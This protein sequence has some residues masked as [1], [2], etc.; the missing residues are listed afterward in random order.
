LS[1]T[2]SIAPSS[3]FGV[4]GKLR[5]PITDLLAFADVPFV[6]LTTGVFE[7]LPWEHRHSSV[8]EKPFSPDVLIA[9]VEKG[10]DPIPRPSQRQSLPNGPVP[11]PQVVRRF[12]TAPSSMSGS[13]ERVFCR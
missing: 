8:V 2:A 11:L 7:P 10:D 4:D 9:A 3:I 5:L 13:F 6:F 1:A 12:R